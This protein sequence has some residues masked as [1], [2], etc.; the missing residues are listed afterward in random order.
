M[1]HPN[2]NDIHSHPGSTSSSDNNIQKIT[3][4]E[5]EKIRKFSTQLLILFLI[6]L[7]TVFQPTLLLNIVQQLSVTAKRE[8]TSTVLLA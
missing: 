5:V 2:H 7:L 3:N 8:R 1:L 6:S 4:E